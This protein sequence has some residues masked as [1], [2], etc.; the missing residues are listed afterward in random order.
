MQYCRSC[1]EQGEKI[2]QPRWILNEKKVHVMKDK[3]EDPGAWSNS[4]FFV[5]TRPYPMLTRMTTLE[6]KW[7]ILGNINRVLC[8]TKYR[9]TLL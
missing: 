8:Y 5:P 1:I 6:P 4:T 9:K 3:D 7:L 2:Q